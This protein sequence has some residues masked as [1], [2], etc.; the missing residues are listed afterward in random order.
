MLPGVDNLPRPV[1]TTEAL[2][3]AGSIGGIKQ[4]VVSKL[5]QLVIGKQVQGEALS[6]L[7]DGTFLSKSQVLLREWRCRTIPSPVTN[8]L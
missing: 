1:S 5:D 6:R 2:S 3:A 8:W 7:N 4:D